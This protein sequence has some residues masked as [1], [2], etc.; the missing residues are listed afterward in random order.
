MGSL[1]IWEIPTFHNQQKTFWK[2]TN[3]KNLQIVYEDKLSAKWDS[4]VIFL[5]H[6]QSDQAQDKPCIRHANHMV[7]IGKGKL[8]EFVCNDRACISKSKQR[9]ISKYW[10]HPHRVCVEKRIMA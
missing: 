8:Q 6:K 3:C 10:F 9:M 1:E 2:L 4:G 5:K 7:S